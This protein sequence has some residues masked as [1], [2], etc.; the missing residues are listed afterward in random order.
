M[1]QVWQ[2]PL[3]NLLCRKV[4]QVVGECLIDHSTPFQQLSALASD[5]AYILPWLSTS[6][7]LVLVPRREEVVQ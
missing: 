6:S 5:Q 2:N 3:K 7:P 4:L 1:D